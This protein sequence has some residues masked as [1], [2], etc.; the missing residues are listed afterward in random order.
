MITVDNPLLRDCIAY[1]IA[2]KHGAKKHKPYEPP[3]DGFCREGARPEILEF[4]IDGEVVLRK[5]KACGMI[6]CWLRQDLALETLVAQVEAAAEKERIIKEVSDYARATR[7][8]SRDQQAETYVL[9]SAL[10]HAAVR[11]NAKLGRLFDMDSRGDKTRGNL[12]AALERAAKA[13][14]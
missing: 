7:Q 12:A 3:L 8:H 2:S 1:G 5:V 14:V 6:E 10:L 11:R 13:G 9:S 4:A